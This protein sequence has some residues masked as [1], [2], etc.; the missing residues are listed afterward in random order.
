MEG[1][2]QTQVYTWHYVAFVLCMAA[3][4]VFGHVIRGFVNPF[5]DRL[6][7]SQ[8]MDMIL[9]DGYDMTDQLFGT[10][11]DDAGFYRLD[12]L[13]NLRLSVA[14]WIIGGSVIYLFFEGMAPLFAWA[15]NNATIWFWQLIV[16]R[17]EN[18]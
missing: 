9:S 15:A 10:E 2:F 18:V 14:F 13:K 1:I 11:Y 4:G 17:F 16:Y 5:P 8:A 3:L 6:S 7:D 12:S